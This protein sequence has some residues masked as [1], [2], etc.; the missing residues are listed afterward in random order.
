M[1]ACGGAGPGGAAMPL[2]NLLTELHVC[3][4]SLAHAMELGNYALCA[5][6]ARTDLLLTVSPAVHSAS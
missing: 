3:S 1:S 5:T 6:Y 4:H 2:L